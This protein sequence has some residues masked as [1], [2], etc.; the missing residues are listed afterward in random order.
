MQ[1][2]TFYPECYSTKDCEKLML[3]GF[4]PK[5]SLY[6]EDEKRRK[7]KHNLYT[8]RLGEIYS[9][10]IGDYWYSPRNLK[11]PTYCLSDC[12]DRKKAFYFDDGFRTENRKK[13]AKEDLEKSG[14]EKFMEN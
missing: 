11:C 3:I 1:L 2:S 4:N 12:K 7:K 6:G 14:K 13:S 5:F 8:D 9:H 10:L